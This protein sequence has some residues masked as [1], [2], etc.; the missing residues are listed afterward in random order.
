ML[1]LLPPRTRIPDVGGGGGVG[2]GGGFNT[3]AWTG[4]RDFS[5]ASRLGAA[6]ACTPRAGGSHVA[7]RL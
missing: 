5:D 2:E 4:G 6:L 3:H 1:A 7:F